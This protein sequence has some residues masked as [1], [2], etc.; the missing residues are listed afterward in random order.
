V[1]ATPEALSVGT[2]MI[3]NVL[4]LDPSGSFSTSTVAFDG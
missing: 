2:S 4:Y 3:R 1:S